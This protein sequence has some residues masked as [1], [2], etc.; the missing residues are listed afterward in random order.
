MENFERLLSR[1]ESKELPP[2][3]SR[4]QRQAERAIFVLHIAYRFDFQ[5]N[6][7]ILRII[8]LKIDSNEQLCS[9]K[10]K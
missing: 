4:E 5:V 6:S 2:T 8:G 10:N 3:S 7:D 1:K 9:T